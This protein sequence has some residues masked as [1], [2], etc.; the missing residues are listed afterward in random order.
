[1]PHTRQVLR[2][3]WY[4]DDYYRCP[5]LHNQSASNTVSSEIGAPLLREDAFVSLKPWCIQGGRSNGGVRA[6]RVGTGW[7]YCH[8]IVKQ[9]GNL[10]ED[11]PPPPAMAQALSDS[12]ETEWSPAA[13]SKHVK[14]QKRKTG[15]YQLFLLWLEPLTSELNYDGDFVVMIMLWGTGGKWRK[16]TLRSSTPYIC[17]CYFILISASSAFSGTVSVFASGYM[18]LTL[19]LS[20]P[21]LFTCRK[22]EKQITVLVR[23]CVSHAPCGIALLFVYVNEVVF[24]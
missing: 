20:S 7:V 14:D 10:T 12:R 4:S 11:P 15:I 13:G 18:S 5:I 24:K 23:L 19:L 9:K 8:Q 1:M 22:S 21:W 16:L 6:S 2:K 3:G 17:L